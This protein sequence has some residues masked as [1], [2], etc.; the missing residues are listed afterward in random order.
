[1]STKKKTAK[2]I[3]ENTIT[4]SSVCI[5]DLEEKSIIV[6]P[7]ER[8]RKPLPKVSGMG[9]GEWLTDGTFTWIKNRWRRSHA[10]LIKK[11]NHGKLVKTKDGYLRAYISTKITD[12]EDFGKILREEADEM[13]RSCPPSPSQREGSNPLTP[14]K[15]SR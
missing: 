9:R 14:S 7:Q 15:G 13:A 4:L 8:L 10:V 11:T 3:D 6:A 2:A 5:Y 12:R 1:M